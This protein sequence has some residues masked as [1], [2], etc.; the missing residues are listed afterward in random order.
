[1]AAE[2]K[3]GNKEL[4]G[5]MLYSVRT[6]PMLIAGI[7]ILNTALSYCYIDCVV[8]TYLVQFLFILFIYIASYYFKFCKWHRMFIH[9]IAL[10]LVINII[11]YHWEIPIPNRGMFVLY[12]LI[13]GIFLFIILKLKLRSTKRK[14]A[15]LAAIKKEREEL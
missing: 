8:L 7:Y 15:L 6:I 2:E 4:K 14:R 12:V 10:T 1:M 9:Y 13:T 5:L 3:C 11:D